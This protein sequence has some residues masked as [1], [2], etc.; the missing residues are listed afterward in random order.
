MLFIQ[1]QISIIDHD[2]PGDYKHKK[3]PEMMDPFR[4]FDQMNIG[5]STLNEQIYT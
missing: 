4:P 1:T 2:K 3:R 5:F